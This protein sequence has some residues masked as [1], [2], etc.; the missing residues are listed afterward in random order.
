MKSFE[1]PRNQGWQHVATGAALPTANFMEH[2][3]GRRR[4]C[5]ARVAVSAGSG[6]A[7]IGRLRNV[8][9]SGALM[10]TSLPLSLFTQ[11]AVAVL[12]DDGSRYA[13]F[14]ATVVRRGP[15]GIGIEW[16]ESASGPICAA[17]GCARHCEF[18]GD[19]A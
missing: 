14:T 3:W 2:R 18:S 9:I 7:G 10:E 4:P 17:L 11:I 1:S 16:A 13:E 19:I 5:K 12:R 8:S 15:D 6:V